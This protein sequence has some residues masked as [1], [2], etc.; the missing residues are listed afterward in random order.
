[1][2]GK[3]KLE[4]QSTIA[5]LESHIE[6]RMKNQLHNLGTSILLAEMDT[7][8]SPPINMP[9]LLQWLNKNAE[10]VFEDMDSRM[11]IDKTNWVLYDFW[12][13][14]VQLYVSPNGDFTFTSYGINRKDDGGKKDDI[15]YTLNIGD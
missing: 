1:M 11:T 4:Q 2:I 15:V 5:Y 9:E 14:P 7:K 6:A 13:S 3:Q 12:G 10:Y 8:E